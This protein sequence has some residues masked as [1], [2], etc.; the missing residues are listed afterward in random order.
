LNIE[1]YNTILGTL[2]LMKVGIILD[3][4]TPGAV[5]IGDKNVPIGKVSSSKES[6]KEGP[7]TKGE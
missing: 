6:S 2:F 1:Y 3:F 5:R 4:S 7:M